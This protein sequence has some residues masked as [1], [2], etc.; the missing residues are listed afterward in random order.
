MT[1]KNT[2]EA[3]TLEHDCPPTPKPGEEGKPAEVVPESYSKL[4]ETTVLLCMSTPRP[5]CKHCRTSPKTLPKTT[6]R[7]ED[8]EQ[9]QGNRLF[10]GLSSTVDD[11]QPT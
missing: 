3:R 11:F 10:G 8:E 2:A 4:L 9:G 1:D 6:P 7:P 5:L